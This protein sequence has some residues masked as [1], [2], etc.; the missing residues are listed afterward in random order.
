V[1]DDQDSKGGSLD[2]M[3][4]YG[5]RELCRGHLKK[6]AGN[7]VRDEFAIPQSKL[8]PIIVPL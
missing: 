2:E 6:K 3:P 8:C 4:Y 5:E 7:Q 1:R